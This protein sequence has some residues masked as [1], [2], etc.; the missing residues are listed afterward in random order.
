M[1]GA[2]AN[3]VGIGESQANAIANTWNQLR[4]TIANVFFP[5]FGQL[6]FVRQKW[7]RESHATTQSRAPGRITFWVSY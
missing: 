1:A 6:N 5:L 3:L 7:A 4:M 2:A